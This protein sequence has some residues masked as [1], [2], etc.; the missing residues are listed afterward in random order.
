[1]ISINCALVASI[2]VGDFVDALFNAGEPVGGAVRVVSTG[3][4]VS[5][6]YGGEMAG[7]ELEG[8]GERLQDA[9]VTAA[10]DVGD[11]DSGCAAHIPPL[12]M[13]VQPTLKVRVGQGK[14]CTGGGVGTGGER[15]CPG[16]VLLAGGGDDY[17]AAGGAA[18]FGGDRGAGAGHLRKHNDGAK[19][20]LRHATTDNRHHDGFDT[21]RMGV[22]HDAPSS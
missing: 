18:E 20:C 9:V 7:V 6:G 16:V 11:E 1:M 22:E 14:R 21:P 12:R 3:W 5:G 19:D 2:R 13:R 8:H 10:L 17:W 4:W 15:G